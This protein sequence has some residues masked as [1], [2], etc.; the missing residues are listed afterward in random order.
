MLFVFQSDSLHGGQVSL[1]TLQPKLPHCELTTGILVFQSDSLHRGQFTLVTDITGKAAS[2]WTHY[3]NSCVSVWQPPRRSA[4]RHCSQSCL[5]LNSL[6]VLLCFSLRA[7]MEVSWQKLQP[8]LPHLELTTGTIVFQSESLHGGQLTEITAKAASPWTHYRYYCVSVWQ[9][10]RRSGQLTDIAAK[11][12]SPWI[13]CR[14]SCVW[15]WP[16]PRSAY[17][18]CSQSCLTL[19]S[20]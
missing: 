5:T 7:S 1:L 10:P 11:A 12:A 8:K 20:L 15:V 6:Q 14:Y 4:Y 16:P 17:R 2:P 13:H 9:P 18:H 3:R 19:N